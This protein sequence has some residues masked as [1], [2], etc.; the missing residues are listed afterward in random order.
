MT[1][2][3]IRKLAV[4]VSS[5]IMMT[6]LPVGPGIRLSAQGTDE[7]EQAV[8][9]QLS[10]RQEAIKEKLVK[11]QGH[12]QE[13][14]KQRDAKLA[15][16]QQ[17]LDKVLEDAR[18]KNDER[19]ATAIDNLQKI[20]ASEEERVAVRVYHQAIDAAVETRRTAFDEAQQQFRN[21]LK[22]L[23]EGRAAELSA[24][25]DNYEAAID[26]AFD[27]ANTRCSN[28][29]EKRIIRAEL[30]RDL[31]AARLTYRQDKVAQ[32]NLSSGLKQLIQD[33]KATEKAATASF[34]AALKE[35]RDEL[36]LVLH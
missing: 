1:K 5:S 3:I 17:K 16:L 35:A 26:R 30:I 32:A 13:T 9:K 34:E 27:T 6:L 2:L 20:A 36:R 11:Q 8:C 33:R 18:Q 25:M 21:R 14:R 10:T 28:N 12:L 24:S 19:R 29:E 7:Q 4:V 22:Q 15:S 31:Q 23:M